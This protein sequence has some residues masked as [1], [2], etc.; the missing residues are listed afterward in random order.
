[1][2][3]VDFEWV[4]SQFQAAGVRKGPGSAVLKLLEAWE[5]I[6]LPADLA[7]DAIDIFAS[8]AK[9]A[10]LIKTPT[11][12]TWVQAVP[13]GSLRVSHKVRVKHNAFKGDAGRIHNGR[14]GVVTA[15]RSGDVIFR[16]TDGL[17]PFI[18]NAHYPFQALEVLI[19]Q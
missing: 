18:D 15:I 10:A 14:K 12:E 2:P 16:S 7:E 8:V 3:K 9:N 5:E 19:K 17:E 1:M 4:K 11:N 13:G 6:E